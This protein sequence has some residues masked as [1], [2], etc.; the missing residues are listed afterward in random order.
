MHGGEGIMSTTI[1]WLFLPSTTG[2]AWIEC[3]VT[4]CSYYYGCAESCLLFASDDLAS[5]Q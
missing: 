4:T 5:L 1:E 2:Q 3:E